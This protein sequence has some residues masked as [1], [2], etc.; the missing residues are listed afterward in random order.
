MKKLLLTIL[1]IFM[2][3]AVSGCSR[4]RLSDETTDFE[5]F[6]VI[7]T[8]A[9][10]DN[11]VIYEVYDKD[12]FVVYFLTESVSYAGFLTYNLCPMYGTDGKVAIYAWSNPN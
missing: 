5:R 6:V 8:L 12:T 1:L 4:K 9:K 10:R 7:K 11:T 3:V 2:M